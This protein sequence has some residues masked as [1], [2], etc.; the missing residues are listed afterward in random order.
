MM[1]L[2]DLDDSKGLTLN[3]T[4][5]RNDSTENAKTPSSDDENK[6]QSPPRALVTDVSL[7]VEMQKIIQQARADMDALALA[8]GG[9][10][11]KQ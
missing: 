8:H 7:Q 1:Y 5:D 6:A 11:E 10:P 9:V 4:D 2:V 3:I